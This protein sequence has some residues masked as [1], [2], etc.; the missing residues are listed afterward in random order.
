[1][2]KKTIF[3]SAILASSLCLASTTNIDTK[4]AEKG[5]MV[6]V[7]EKT[8]MLHAGKK[9]AKN[10]LSERK[11]EIDKSKSVQE[12]TVFDYVQQR[13]AQ[14]QKKINEVRDILHF[15]SLNKYAKRVQDLLE[16]AEAGLKSGEK[17]EKIAQY[18]SEAMEAIEKAKNEIPKANKLPLSLQ[19]N[20]QD[21][22]ADAAEAKKYLKEAKSLID[23]RDLRKAR[24]ILELTQSEMDILVEV[25]PMK[26][27]EDTLILANHYLQKGD[28][29]TAQTLIKKAK[30]LKRT[31]TVVVPIPPMM[32]AQYIEV[33]KH[34]KD[35]EQKTLLLKKAYAM[36]LKGKELGYYTQENF[37]KEKRELEAYA[38]DQGIDKEK[39][40]PSASDMLKSK[41][42]KAVEMFR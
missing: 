1:M 14:L 31:I 23:K 30:D 4:N 24:V 10:A 41:I 34:T 39:I 16:K 8:G 21:F 15:E 32:A 7:A 12:G 22:P 13:N 36:M 5:F 29:K 35:K 38:K 6:S 27:L 37:E 11:K 9:T 33:A 42:R 3:L 26:Q 25:F 2:G 20:F 40:I 18:V 28:R 19:G 17:E